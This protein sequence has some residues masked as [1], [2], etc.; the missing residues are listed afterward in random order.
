MVQEIAEAFVELVTLFG[1]L[2][3]LAQVLMQIGGA[4]SPRIKGK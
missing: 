3:F 1:G 2:V 4:V